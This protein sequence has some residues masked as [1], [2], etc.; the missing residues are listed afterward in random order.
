MKRQLRA[1]EVDGIAAPTGIFHLILVFVLAFA[2]QVPFEPPLH[3][4]VRGA[5]AERPAAYEP[6]I[7]LGRAE[8]G[9]LGMV[10]RLQAEKK[11][12]NRQNSV[13]YYQRHVRRRTNPSRYDSCYVSYNYKEWLSC[14]YCVFYGGGRRVR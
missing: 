7:V 14:S 4:P 13:D 10:E 2:P 8:R 5:G 6:I 1:R 9:V 11:S 12:N 3:R